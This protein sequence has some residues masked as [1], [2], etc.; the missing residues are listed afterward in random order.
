MNS[1]QNFLLADVGAGVDEDR[2]G[3]RKRQRRRPVLEAVELP[4]GADAD[5]SHAI[6]IQIS[7]VLHFPAEAALGLPLF[8]HDMQRHVGLGAQIAREHL[9]IDLGPAPAPAT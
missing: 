1:D 7:D 4:D 6:A 2:A 3:E 5:V 8:A 9:P